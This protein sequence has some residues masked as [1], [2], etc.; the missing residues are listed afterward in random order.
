[1]DSRRQAGDHS[2]NQALCR[3]VGFVGV[4][5]LDALERGSAVVLQGR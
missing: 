5:F 2:A 1:V 4:E 3:A